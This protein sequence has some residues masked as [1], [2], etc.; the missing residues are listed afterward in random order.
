MKMQSGQSRISTDDLIEAFSR[1]FIG[2]SIIANLEHD[3]AEMET[4]LDNHITQPLLAR[5]VDSSDLSQ[6]PAEELAKLSLKTHVR[7]H[8]ATEARQLGQQEL[9]Q[10]QTQMQATFE[11]K[12]IA[13]SAEPNSKPFFGMWRNKKTGQYDLGSASSG[14]V[15]GKITAINLGQNFFIVSAGTL[16]KLIQ[17]TRD[18]FVVQVINPQTGQSQIR[19]L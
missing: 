19:F 18:A 17:P 11:G 16:S 4:V 5:K 8:Q 3:A 9:D 12:Q 7:K 1:V 13:I 14:K 2:Q 6:I 10:L 15:K